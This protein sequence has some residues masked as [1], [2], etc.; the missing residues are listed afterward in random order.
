VTIDNS[1]RARF[2]RQLRDSAQIARGVLFVSGLLVVAATLFL[3]YTSSV[4]SAEKNTDFTLYTGRILLAAALIVVPG[5]L[6]LAFSSVWLRHNLRI[7]GARSTAI[8]FAV[9]GVVLVGVGLAIL[10]QYSDNALRGVPPR[11]LESSGDV[12]ASMVWL[13]IGSVAII[14]VAVAATLILSYVF[15]TRTAREL[16]IE[17]EPAPRARFI[18]FAGVAALAIAALAF[19]Y[20]ALFP[21]PLPATAEEGHAFD[22]VAFLPFDTAT[23]GQ[24]PLPGNARLEFAPQFNPEFGWVQDTPYPDAYT[25]G[26]WH[27]ED[28]CTVD[29]SIEAPG[30]YLPGDDQTASENALAALVGTSESPITPYRDDFRFAASRAALEDDDTSWWNAAV[31]LTDTRFVAVRSLS[32]TQTTVTIDAQC[33]NPTTFLESDIWNNMVLV[34]AN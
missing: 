23:D 26:S 33:A 17:P 13:P 16:R 15:L 11:T 2:D 10:K 12:L 4:D 25:A 29:Y 27:S 34:G 9:F 7:D 22:N 6:L 31:Y 18:P 30:T 3:A 21:A 32:E 19:G 1:S 5:A 8:T 20:P 24:N 28:G 14:V